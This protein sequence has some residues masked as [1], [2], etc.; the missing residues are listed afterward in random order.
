VYVDTLFS[1]TNYVKVYE[2]QVFQNE[3]NN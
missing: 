3:K 1:S 2:E